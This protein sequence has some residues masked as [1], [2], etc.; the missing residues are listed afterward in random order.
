MASN[1]KA[2]DYAKTAA[3]QTTPCSDE[4]VPYALLKETSLSHMSRSATEVKPRASA[5][6]IASNVRPERR[7]RPPPGRGL[8]HQHLRSTKKE[9][10]GRYYQSLSGHGAFGSYL[11]HKIHKVD[12]DR[13][14]WCDT[15]ERQSRFH[16]VVRCPARA[17][18]A[19]AM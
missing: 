13:C 10:A 2:D 8:R 4:E 3:R 18:Q 6:W 5:E 1:E 11:W 17:S 19:L 14:W 12:S 7:Y 15:G 16:L 9:W